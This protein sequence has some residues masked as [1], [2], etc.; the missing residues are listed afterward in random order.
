MC[1][2][3]RAGLVLTRVHRE[4]YPNS[5]TNGVNFLLWRRITGR[6]MPIVEGGIS[7]L[8]YRASERLAYAAIGFPEG[9]AGAL[10]RFKGGVSDTVTRQRERRIRAA[11]AE[12]ECVGGGA[13]A[14]ESAIDGRIAARNGS[15]LR[16]QSGIGPSNVRDRKAVETLDPLRGEVAALHFFRKRPTGRGYPDGTVHGCTELAEIDESSDSH[17]TWIGAAIAATTMTA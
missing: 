6:A 15:L 17:W 5:Q 13:G 9:I 3:G 1:D 2:L 7:S 16:T 11:I 10:P 12:F 4:G 14:G 8:S